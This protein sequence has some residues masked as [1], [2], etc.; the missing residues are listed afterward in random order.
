MRPPTQPLEV[1]LD[2]LRQHD[3]H[4]SVI[5]HSIVLS[6][7]LATCRAPRWI[8]IARK[9]ASRRPYPRPDPDLHERPGRR[10][11]RDRGRGIDKARRTIQRRSLLSSRRVLSLRPSPSGRGQG[12]G[13]FQSAEAPG[14]DRPHWNKAGRG[15]AVL[16]GPDEG[17]KSA[18]GE[19]PRAFSDP[20]GDSSVNERERNPQGFVDYPAKQHAK[21]SPDQPFTFSLSAI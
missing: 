14:S 11:R 10:R 19:S 13:L 1:L 3:R 9:G 16:A 2:P 18:P 6:G 5:L 4:L 15:L 7:F 8:P 12:E 21:Q 17:G 20:R